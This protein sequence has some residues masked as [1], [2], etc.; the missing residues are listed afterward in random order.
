MKGRRK[1]STMTASNATSPATDPF[2]DLTHEEVRRN[3][4]EDLLGFCLDFDRAHR[5]IEIEIACRVSQAFDKLCLAH[6]SKHG[7]Y[8]D[9]LPAAYVGLADGVGALGDETCDL[10]AIVAPYVVD[11]VE[12]IAPWAPK[13]I[14]VWESLEVVEQHPLA[15]RIFAKAGISHRLMTL[16]ERYPNLRDDEAEQ[17]ELEAAPPR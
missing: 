13:S 3:L 8:D 9:D 6:R 17:A 10:V 2:R 14:R 15:A 4:T 11:A 16:D 7:E 5:H 12:T 1:E